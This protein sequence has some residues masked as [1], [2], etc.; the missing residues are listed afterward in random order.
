MIAYTTEKMVEHIHE[1]RDRTP[2]LVVQVHTHPTG[3]SAL[4]EVDR[5]SMPEVARR[6]RELITHRGKNK[7]PLKVKAVNYP[8]LTDGA[9]PSKG[10]SGG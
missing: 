3:A 2:G 8:A 1:E 7:Q 5:E 6:V 9:C 4:F 10:R